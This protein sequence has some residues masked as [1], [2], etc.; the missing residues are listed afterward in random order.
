MPAFDDTVNTMF[1]V[2]NTP[3]LPRLDGMDSVVKDSLNIVCMAEGLSLSDK[4]TQLDMLLLR[5]EVYLKK[6]YYL[7]HGEELP[8]REEGQGATLSNAIFAFPALRGL[9]N[10]PKPEYQEFSQRL[11]LLRQLRNQES[12]GSIEINEQEVDAAIRIV[13]DMYLFV[14]GMNVDNL[15]N[16]NEMTDGG[17]MTPLHPVGYKA[18]EESD[19]PMAAEDIFVYGSIP[20]DLPKTNKKD[21][22]NNKLDLVLMYAIN[23]AARKKTEAAGKIALGIKEKVL[24]EIQKT[25]YDSVK[26][27]MFH[28]WKDPKPFLL[29]KAPRLVDAKDVPADFLVRQPNDAVKYLLLE[30]NPN[31]PHDTDD[32]DIMKTQRRGEI[33]YLPFVT[34]IE[35]ITKDLEHQ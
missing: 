5:Y 34:T 25:S 17:N 8:S 4:R 32:I 6:L 30:Y 16:E 2:L 13:I 19:W 23:P 12:H 28:Y 26:Y 9:K 29:T 24:N 33:R 11:S 14:T 35:S 20:V 10:N 7:I 27:L 15:S 22:V 1:R 31:E 3:S 18:H 21:L